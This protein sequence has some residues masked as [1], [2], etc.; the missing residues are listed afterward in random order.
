MKIGLD[1][2]RAFYN[3]RGLGNYSRDTIRILSEQ[4]SDEN[5]YLFT[6]QKE[7]KILFSH[8]ENCEIITPHG[9]YKQSSSLWRTFGIVDDINKLD[10]DIYHG[11]SNELPLK[12]NKTRVHS[13]LTMHDL[14]FL[15]FPKLYPWIDRQLYKRKYISSCEISDIIIAISEQTKKDLIELI[16]IKEEKIKVV[17][18]G[19]NP[20]F[21]QTFSEKEKDIIREKYSLPNHFLLSVGAIEPRKNHELTIKS[22]AIGQIDIPYVIVGHETSYLA[23]L[24]RIVHENKVEDK[25]IFLTK[26]PLVDLP[27]I[28]QMSDIFIYPSVFEGFGIPILEALNSGIPVIT[29]KGSCFEETGGNGSCYINHEDPEELSQAIIEILSNENKR[30]EMIENGFAHAELFSDEQISTNLMS[31]YKE[32]KYG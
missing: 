16:G 9:L 15:K 5:F 13:V 6:P 21:Q 10:I 26:V 2:K 32:L 7:G 19:C 29:S 22:L 25:V 28:Y 24:K 11:L 20:I 27:T 12:I 31:I 1:A 18:Q 30:K 23:E 8:N 4:N 17:Y 14:I 3:S